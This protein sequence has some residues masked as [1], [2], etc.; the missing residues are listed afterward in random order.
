MR[1]A[2]LNRSPTRNSFPI[3]L[4]LQAVEGCQHLA[5]RLLG[6]LLV[7]DAVANPRERRREPGRQVTRHLAT[8]GRRR[9]ERV[10][11]RAEAFGIADHLVEAQQP[12]GWTQLLV[13]VVLQVESPAA[14]DRV[15]GVER[16]LRMAPLESADDLRRVADHLAVE[17][18]DGEGVDL[19][20]GQR[21]GSDHVK[22]AGH[23]TP[24]VR[25]PLEVEGP[26]RLLAVVRD[27]DMPQERFRGTH[28]DKPIRPRPPVSLR[29]DQPPVVGLA[30]VLELQ[31]EPRPA[32]PAGAG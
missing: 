5:P 29:G 7:P 21:Q 11:E 8:A 26:A 2:T 6:A 27:P 19:A 4:R 28:V 3:Q 24:P 31:L 10:H 14:L 20:V 18:Q 30:A 17:L 25:N 13:E 16:R 23:R 1:S 22:S 12:E 15:L 9:E 32:A